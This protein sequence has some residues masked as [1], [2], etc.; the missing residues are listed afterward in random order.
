MPDP[1]QPVD[2]VAGEPTEADD[3]NTTNEAVE[4]ANSNIALLAEAAGP[5]NGSFEFDFDGDG[6][7]DEWDVEDFA[8]GSHSLDTTNDLH[9]ATALACVT[10]V[11][12]GYVQATSD[13]FIPVAG[14]V[15]HVE[16]MGV[17]EVLTAANRVRFQILWY[18]DAQTTVVGTAAIFDATVNTGGVFQVRGEAIAPSTARYYKTRL[19]A[20]ESG[21]STA[22][23]I[24]FDGIRTIVFQGTVWD[25]KTTETTHSSTT[26]EVIQA[27]VAGSETPKTALLEI[28]L[29]VASAPA[30]TT[31]CDVEVDGWSGSAW[32][33]NYVEGR[34]FQNASGFNGDSDTQWMWCRV[35]CDQNGQYRVRTTIAL[36]GGTASAVVRLVG[37]D[38]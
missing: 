4:A 25:G 23:T 21:G 15:E 7:P 17:V 2:V 5:S 18:D 24:L 12:G 9:G 1:V 31:T 29:N 13:Q 22:S 30:A 14:G 10:T 32:S 3:L 27:G 19:I 35:R 6:E 28:E 8:G 26:T 37:Y 16:Q 11:G 20:G 34:W 38:V 33:T 36:N